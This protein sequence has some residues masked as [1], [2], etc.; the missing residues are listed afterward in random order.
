MELTNESA[1]LQ[2]VYQGAAMGAD[3][4]RYLLPKVDNPRF[5]S[6]LQTQQEQY[7]QTAANA[8]K[9]MKALGDCPKDLGS[10]QQSMLWAC[11]QGKTLCNK[12]T[13]HLA[14]LMIQG[15][16]MGIVNL[17]KVL[18]SY[19]PA[20]PLDDPAGQQAQQ[21]ARELAQTAIQAEEDN[22]NRLKTYLQ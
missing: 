16:S 2:E 13:S 1:L 11:V 3:A 6:D 10:G 12:E 5:R 17:T 21:Q 19:T 15:S 7:R 8:E 18:N 4:I 14:E 20:D 9:Q 22:I